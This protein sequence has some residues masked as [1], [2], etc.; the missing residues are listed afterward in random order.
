MADAP[1]CDKASE[2]SRT[3][4]PHPA[5]GH[6]LMLG[7]DSTN[8]WRNADS[9]IICFVITS[10]LCDLYWNNHQTVILRQNFLCSSVIFS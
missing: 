7:F 6:H 8:A 10:L 2:G 1:T 9:V 5:T 4:R 3:A